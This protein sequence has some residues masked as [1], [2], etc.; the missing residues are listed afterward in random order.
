MS[1]RKELELFW[2]WAGSSPEIYA[3]YNQLK[4]K[5]ETDYCFGNLLHEVEKL[6]KKSDISDCEYDNLLTAMAL[7]N[8]VEGILDLCSEI[9]T[10]QQI[11]KIVQIGIKHIQANARWQVAELLSRRPIK[12]ANKYLSILLKDDS[13]YVRKRAQNSLDDLHDNN[14]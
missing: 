7:D 2:I 8:E 1:L 3:K 5:D 4:D 9:A 14:F 12:N 11:V 13:P 10:D 6:L